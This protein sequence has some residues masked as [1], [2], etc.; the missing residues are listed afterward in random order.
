ML[1]DIPVSTHVRRITIPR[2]RIP[3]HQIPFNCN[4]LQRTV[5]RIIT[6]LFCGA[7]QT[8][9]TIASQLLLHGRIYSNPSRELCYKDL[10][11]GKT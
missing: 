4:V 10:S 11:P 6:Y 8:E 9:H 1:S 5:L 2:R 3:T 7:I